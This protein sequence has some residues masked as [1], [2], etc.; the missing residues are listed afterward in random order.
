[1]K[2]NKLKFLFSVLL[3]SSAFVGCEDESST[4]NPLGGVNYVSFEASK[5]DYVADGE[6]KVIEVKVATSKVEGFDREIGL[7]VD[8]SSTMN[9]A[10]YTVPT[11]VTIPAG[12]NVATIDITVTGVNI[13]PQKTIV[14]GIVS[15][16]GLVLAT[17]YTGDGPAG[18]LQTATKKHTLTIKEICYDNGL[19]VEIVTDRYG[20]ETTWELYD[21]TM[22]LIASGGP[23]TDAAASGAYP[24]TPNDFCLPSGD[25]TFVA[26]DQYSDGMD[27]GYGNGY[28]RLTKRDAY[29]QEVSEIAKNGVFGD[30]DVVTFS[31]P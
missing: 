19:R 12:T 2:F 26:Y 22:T 31:L 6:T 21:S 30:S 23:Y 18:T 4:D 17:T 7:V 5:T 27:S 3:L 11:S 13:A 29:G 9:P 20:S 8:A 14:L 16:P 24:Q 15:E 28:Y 1:M 25:Y 10:N